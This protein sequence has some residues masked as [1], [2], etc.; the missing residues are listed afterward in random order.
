[1]GKTLSEDLDLHLR[2]RFDYWTISSDG[3]KVVGC[4]HNDEYAVILNL[5]TMEEIARINGQYERF[6]WLSSDTK[7]MATD[8]RVTNV[9]DGQ[10]GK[11]LYYVEA[12]Y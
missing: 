5:S 10:T 8:F 1:M 6:A 9:Y 2:E 3:S 12:T 11:Y 4:K 7:I